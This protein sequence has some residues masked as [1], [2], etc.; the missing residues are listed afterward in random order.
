MDRITP[1]VSTENVYNQ[2]MIDDPAFRDLINL[3]ALRQ[4]AQNEIEVR[5]RIEREIER[6]GVVV[7]G[8]IRLRL[9]SPITVPQSK[10]YIN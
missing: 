9:A 1:I 10:F 5:E 7:V 2:Q 3:A 4:I 6:G 8:G